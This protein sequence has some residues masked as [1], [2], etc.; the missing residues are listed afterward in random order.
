[1]MRRKK[2][3]CVMLSMSVLVGSLTGMAIP[4]GGWA[5]GLDKA[6][7]EL[8]QLGAQAAQHAKKAE[9]AALEAEQLANTLSG[10]AKNDAQEAAQGARQKATQA[11]AKADRIQ[12]QASKDGDVGNL[13][14]LRQA[15]QDAKQ[16]GNEAQGH[17]KRARNV[18]DSF[19]AS[20]M[21][22]GDTGMTQPPSDQSGS[23]DA[24]SSTTSQRRRG[25]R[26][27]APPSDGD[28]SMGPQSSTD[29]P[30]SRSRDESQSGQTLPGQ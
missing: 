10:T 13:D 18:A 4:N 27:S 14:E 20:R 26:N 16:M 7:Q 12:G 11:K 1:M 15:A 6:R 5:Q 8:Q 25:L 21:D 30:R 17:A 28:A 29:S 9:Q 3:I 23:M 24:G 2:N 22:K 19:S